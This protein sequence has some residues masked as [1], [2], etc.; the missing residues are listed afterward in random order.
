MGISTLAC[1]LG[2]SALRRKMPH[3][4]LD[5]LNVGLN[6]GSDAKFAWFNQ[7]P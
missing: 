6:V 3:V 7:T 2:D 5:P 1:R 4:Y